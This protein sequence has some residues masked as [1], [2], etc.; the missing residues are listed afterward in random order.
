MNVPDYPTTAL[1]E[2]ALEDARVGMSCG[3]KLNHKH[4]TLNDWDICSAD[5][6][7]GDEVK[8]TNHHNLCCGT[9]QP[10]RT[11]PPGW[12]LT[13]FQAKYKNTFVCNYIHA[14][15]TTATN[16]GKDTETVKIAWIAKNKLEPEGCEFVAEAPTFV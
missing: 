4:Q 3:G 9:A 8:G 16:G 10:G 7:A 12:S 2:K 5:Y 15:Q 13:D 11:A 6:V 1:A 14:P